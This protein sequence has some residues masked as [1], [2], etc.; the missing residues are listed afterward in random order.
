ME[1]KLSSDAFVPN[2]PPTWRH[3]PIHDDD[4]VVY[5]RP[6]EVTIFKVV[7]NIILYALKCY[8]LFSGILFLF[9]ADIV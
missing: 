6:I 3:I 4:V 7:P 9:T 5:A 8:F 1:A 2:L